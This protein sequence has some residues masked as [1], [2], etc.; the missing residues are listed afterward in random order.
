M[1]RLGRDPTDAELAFEL[2][3]SPQTV[4]QLRKAATPPVSLQTPVGEDG[5]TFGD[6]VPDTEGI[7]LTETVDRKLVHDR[8]VAALKTLTD[9]EREVLNYRFG[10]EKG[11][12][13]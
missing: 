5:A 8:L 12:H 7:A 3:I 6:F 13:V 2:S 10:L 1:Q 4:R 9:R 11:K